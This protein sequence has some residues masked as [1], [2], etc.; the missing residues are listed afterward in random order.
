MPGSFSQRSAKSRAKGEGSTVSRS[1]VRPSD[2]ETILEVTMTMSPSA[3]GSPPVAADSTIMAARS[4]PSVISG[5]PSTAMAETATS[6]LP[7]TPA[8]RM[9]VCV[10]WTR[11]RLMSSEVSIS[12]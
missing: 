3:R 9:L 8:M 10:L 4:S 12:T 1:T 11:L 5:R 7:Q 2:L 6:L